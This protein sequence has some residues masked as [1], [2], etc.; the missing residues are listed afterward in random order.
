VNIDKIYYSL[1]SQAKEDVGFP[2]NPMSM[3][4][5]QQSFIE[6]LCSTCFASSSV[7]E[8]LISVKNDLEEILEQL[9]D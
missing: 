5:E 6:A 4:H 3:S 7:R 2:I 8:D 9:Q 1:P